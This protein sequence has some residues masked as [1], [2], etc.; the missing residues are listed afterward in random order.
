MQ[1]SAAAAAAPPP[2]VATHIVDWGLSSVVRPSTAP[3]TGRTKR[4]VYWDGM[5][6]HVVVAPDAPGFRW[7][8]PHLKGGDVNAGPQLGV[9]ETPGTARVKLIGSKYR[10]LPTMEPGGTSM[11]A[12]SPSEAAKYGSTGT[13][14]STSSSTSSTT[15]RPLTASIGNASEY[16]RAKGMPNGVSSWEKTQQHLLSSMEVG[17]PSRLTGPSEHMRA[18]SASFSGLKAAAAASA[19]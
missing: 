9:R 1:S 19:R 11:W 3:A 5:S 6:H 2:A 17:R 10:Y 12:I 8:A 14:T 4:V 7:I 13:F 18:M 15:T 16:A